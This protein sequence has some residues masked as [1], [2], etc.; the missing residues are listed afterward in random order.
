MDVTIHRDASV[1]P[2]AFYNNIDPVFLEKVRGVGTWDGGIVPFS[3]T[4]GWGHWAVLWD[5]GV[6]CW[7][8]GNG[9]GDGRLGPGRCAVLWDG[10]VVCWL[11]GNGLG[12]WNLGQGGWGPR[13]IEH[14]LRGQ[15]DRA[16]VVILLVILELCVC[17]KNLH[18]AGGEGCLKSM[19]QCGPRR[20]VHATSTVGRAYRATL[21]CRVCT[22]W[23]AMYPCFTRS[24]LLQQ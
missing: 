1:D 8:H 20:V 7:L 21:C 24:N 12:G 23:A 2:M 11:H 19:G 22:P 13:L 14:E 18:A 5:G 16:K 4:V 15:A 17:G 3:G 9:L 6:V 10:G